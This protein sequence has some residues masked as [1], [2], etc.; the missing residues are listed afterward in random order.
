M[1]IR[2]TL[3]ILAFCGALLSVAAEKPDE[4]RVIW[5]GTP[6]YQV[7]LRS[8]HLTPD[9]AMQILQ[10]HHELLEGYP[11]RHGVRCI[12]GD[13]YHFTLPGKP[14]TALRGIYV[15]ANTGQI[16]LRDSE[17]SISTNQAAIP[18]DI[19]SETRMIVPP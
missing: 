1:S 3:L 5:T 16:E 8:F 14:R 10:K 6:A 4:I 18:S 11:F 9:D 17:T 13:Y 15:H 12:V 2:K 19:F 7:A